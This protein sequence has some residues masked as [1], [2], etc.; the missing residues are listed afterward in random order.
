[1]RYNIFSRETPGPGLKKSAVSKSFRRLT[2]LCLL[3]FCLFALPGT[4]GA[5][6]DKKE[7][8]LK[9]GPF[10][11]WSGYTQTGYTRWQ[12][13]K[14]GFRIRRSRLG[15]RGDILKNV[16]YKLQIDAVKTRILLDAQ[17]E[18]NFIPQAQLKIGQFKVPFSLE[19]LTS[20]SALDTINRSQTVEN[21]CP[22]RDIGASGRDIGITL[23]GQ[24]S[25]FD[26]SFGIFNGSGINITDLNDHK[27]IA[28]R[29]AFRPVGFL[30]IGLSRYDGR[31][32]SNQGAPA[33][34]RERTGIDIF[35]VQGA[36]AIKGEYIHGKDEQTK[37]SGWY[38]HGNYDLVS[39]RFQAIFRYDSF[40]A[41]LDVR[42]D[43]MT[44]TTV[45]VN[46]FFTNKTKIQLNYEVH[47]KGSG[48]ASKNVILA[49]LQAGF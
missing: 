30:S 40:S 7:L 2:L 47:K 32:S 46:Y 8:K 10:L 17:V 16:H 35:Y 20:S 6:K 24:F 5:G 9:R 33:F 13:G 37:R 38:I 4:S 26:Y 1:M 25:W 39:D 28:A 41:N 43:R 3:I 45:G 29:L 19:N 36:L 44:V 49:Q 21:L 48:E 34:E 31:Y 27:D 18:M 15:F 14:S 11:E 22:G 42:G 12:E 23:N